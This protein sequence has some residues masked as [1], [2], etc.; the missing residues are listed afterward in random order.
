MTKARL[1]DLIRKLLHY[2]CEITSRPVQAPRLIYYALSSVHLGEFFGIDKGW[3]REYGIRTVI[4]IGANTGQ[5]SSAARRVFPEAKIYAF[6]PLEDCHEA[7]CRRM[8]GDRRFTARCVALGQKTGKT[9]FHRNEF[10]KSS[11][12]LEMDRAHKEAFPWTAN[13]SQITVDAEKLDNV[14]PELELERPVLLK[15]DVQGAE[16]DVFLGGEKTLY[17]VDIII[18]ELSFRTLYTGQPLFDDIYGF[19]K[20]RGFDYRGSLDTLE[21]SSDGAA[22]QEN[23]VFVRK[24]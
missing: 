22:V 15:I 14:L 23:G 4:D 12:M 18:A 13:T 5:F 9:A 1:F 24:K 3:L 21:S 19:L 16:M 20:A 11:S 7:L 6:E 10:A 17:V 2:A 8:S